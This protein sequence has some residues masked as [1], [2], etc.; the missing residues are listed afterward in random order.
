ML[1]DPVYGLGPISALMGPIKVHLTRLCHFVDKILTNVPF[2][3]HFHGFINSTTPVSLFNILPQN[4]ATGFFI[5]FSAC[6]SSNWMK[7]SQNVG[8][9]GILS[10]AKNQH[11]FPS[12]FRS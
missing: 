6:V 9:D 11:R 1:H 4:S 5:D 7:L 3:C 2:L 10:H 12:Q 8:L